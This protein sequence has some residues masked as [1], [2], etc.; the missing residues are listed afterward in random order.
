MSAIASTVIW[1]RPEEELP[2][3]NELVVGY[4]P[5]IAQ[6]SAYLTQAASAC[7]ELPCYWDGDVWRDHYDQALP[8]APKLWCNMP[9][10]PESE[11]AR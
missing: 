10:V 11:E 5:N 4:L 8:I 1:H 2:E 7:A 3:V 6:H 9:M